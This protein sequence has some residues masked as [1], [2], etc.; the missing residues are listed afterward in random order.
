M[1]RWIDKS[2]GLDR[3]LLN[4]P[5]RQLNSD[6]GAKLRDRIA[7]SMKVQ[8]AASVRHQKSGA[9]AQVLEK[10]ASDPVAEDTDTDSRSRD[11]QSISSY[12]TGAA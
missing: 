10:T 2:G 12:L 4:T 7:A 8:Q 6:V 9:E 11:P 3:Y 1:C 5:D